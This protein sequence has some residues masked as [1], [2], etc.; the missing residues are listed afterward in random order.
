MKF[1]PT[2]YAQCVP[3]IRKPTLLREDNRTNEKGKP[4]SELLEVRGCGLKS[5]NE[6]NRGSLALHTGNARDGC[7]RNYVIAS[8]AVAQVHGLLGVI[9]VILMP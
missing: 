4:P 2:A 7:L 8:F 1:E 5:H 3:V 6:R 9:V